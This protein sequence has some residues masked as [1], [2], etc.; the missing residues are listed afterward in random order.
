M[1]GSP[2]R[3][4]RHRHGS[5]AGPTA[6]DGTDG[7]ATGM[8]W[9]RRT[10]L[11]VPRHVTST[12]HL[13]ALYP[14][15]LQ[16]G[17]GHN[18]VRLG[19]D[20]LTGGEPFIWD[21]FDAYAAGLIQGPNAVISGAGAHGKSAIAKSYVNR[22]HNR[23]TAGRERFVAVID[24][25]G[26]WTTLAATLGWV[27][28]RLEP[29]GLTRLNPLDVSPALVHLTTTADSQPADS[30]T[31]DAGR[32]DSGAGGAT[33][34]RDMEIAQRSSIAAALL[35]TTLGEPELNATQLR[36]I[37]VAM[38]YL[39]LRS[40]SPMSPGS[41]GTSR[42][43]PTLRDLRDLLAD[44]P[45]GM[46]ADLDTTPAELLTSRR[47]L[48]DACAI[49]IEHELRGMCDGPTNIAIDW[50]TTPGLVVD[51]SALLAHRKA[52]R[53]V[54][55]A[56]YSWLASLMYS[57]PDRHK[58]NILD[59]AWIAL[60]DLPIV[61]YL[62]DQWR[63]GRQWGCANLLITHAIA[64]LQSQANDGSAQNKIANGLLNTT[65]V[66]IFL[67]QQPENIHLLADLGLNTT[68]AALLAHLTPFQAL[69]KVGAHTALV[70]HHITDHEWEFANTDTAMRG[71][72]T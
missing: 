11:T 40:T 19:N 37:T 54:L 45:A 30:P 34:N 13:G 32:G 12:A 15:S 43:A 57:Q 26:E 71:H 24:P 50:S 36:I 59:E 61:R 69:W 48:L 2:R 60:A 20:R 70:D 1:N 23:R 46:A 39:T 4:P 7:V 72:V 21:L 5:D 65:S 31:G 49:L 6:R 18:G 63:L 9:R 10:G 17:L 56:V 47:L 51:L 68:E 52:L 44:P 55:T 14:F 33:E 25:K 22:S 29:G 66:R 41:A 62:Q 53:L 42:S 67:H 64:D 3:D 38:R 16:A 8:P 28:L 58:L 35:A 27:V